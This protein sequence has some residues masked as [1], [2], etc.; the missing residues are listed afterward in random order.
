MT[1]IILSIFLFISTSLLF[2][3]NKTFY[4]VAYIYNNENILDTGTTKLNVRIINEGKIGI[5]SINLM[6]D[7]GKIFLV[8]SKPGDT[9]RYFAI[10]TM[11]SK[12]MYEIQNIQ[13]DIFGRTKSI[14]DRCCV[15][16]N[17][18]NNIKLT[19]GYY[20]IFVNLQKEKGKIRLRRFN[21]SKDK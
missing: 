21:I 17:S 10:P 4:N 16:Q 8:G 11:D 2:S 1:K 15:Y 14:A 9:T 12:P 3:C 19:S 5:S 18:D 13:Y 20:S 6:T 7:S